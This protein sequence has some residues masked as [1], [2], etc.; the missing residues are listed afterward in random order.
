MN[1]VVGTYT[2]C[3]VKV[4]MAKCKSAM[5]AR[6]MIEVDEGKTYSRSGVA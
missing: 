6:V 1:A 3:G 2:K 5:V 4:K